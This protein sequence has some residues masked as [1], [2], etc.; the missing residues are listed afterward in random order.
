MD[1]PMRDS[2]FRL[3]DKTILLTGPFNGVTQALLRTMTELGADIAYVNDKAPTAAKYVDGV[4]EA[5]EAR[6]D[7][8]RSAYFGLPLGTDKQVKDALGRV[9]EGIGRM[10]VYIDAT[11]IGATGAAQDSEFAA[12]MSQQLLPF[13]Q[14]RQRGRIIFLYEDSCLKTLNVEGF[15]D[16]Y[17]EALSEHISL[18]AMTLKDQSVTV[19]GVALG[20]TEDFILRHFAKS[21]S[22]KKSLVELQQRRPGVKLVEALDIATALAFLACP[23]SGSLTGQILRLTHGM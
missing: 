14:A 13:F 18:S 6:P 19:N 21:G 10:D 17:Q 22:I 5:R 1:L 9:S 4:N 11:M 2:P 16:S 12:R 15:V 23:S 7:F 8:G 3:Q 20:V